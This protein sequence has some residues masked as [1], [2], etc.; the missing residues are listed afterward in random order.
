MD[1]TFASNEIVRSARHEQT[2]RIKD[3]LFQTTEAVN[4]V[5]YLHMFKTKWQYLGVGT[6]WYVNTRMM[7]NS[8]SSSSNSLNCYLRMH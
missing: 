4:T 7:T 8:D 1:T 5:K 6:H 2:E 3:N